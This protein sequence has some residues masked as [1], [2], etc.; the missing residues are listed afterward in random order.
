MERIRTLTV[1]DKQEVKKLWKLLFSDSD[2]FTDWYFE[3]RYRP[4]T[5]V[6][7]EKDGQIVSCVLGSQM[8]LRIR[9][10]QVPAMMLSGVSTRPGFEKRGY[11][12]RVMAAMLKLCR[13]LGIP[14]V[15]DKPVDP[16]VY[17]SL[18]H[19]PCTFAKYCTTTG[20]Q[21]SALTDTVDAQ[22]LLACYADATASYSGCVVRTLS[23]MQ[24]KI[25]DCLA[26]NG[27][28]M[29]VDTNGAIAGYAML[30][31]DGAGWECTEALAINEEVYHALLSC[32]P[33]GTRVK[34]P[35]D[36]DVEG[37]LQVQNVMGCANVQALLS[38]VVND[39]NIVFAVYDPIMQENC[40]VFDGTGTPTDRK[41]NFHF[42]AGKLVQALS[43]FHGMLDVM[44]MKPCYCADEY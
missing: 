36:A 13:E 1:S 43:G 6:C 25:D 29:T 24:R 34:V 17:R 3:N 4:E 15:F 41:P 35:A 19:F 39:E 10:K 33:A 8:I 9:G 32:L 14:L 42:S 16:A 37:E 22:A 7:L 20:S 28:F 5:S 40:G 31:P 27:K 21:A 18:G 38:A 44:P 2:S 26:D 30:T 11:M 12:H 23:Q